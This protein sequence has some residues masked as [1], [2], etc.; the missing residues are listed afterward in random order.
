MSSELAAELAGR[1]KEIN[2]GAQATLLMI[3]HLQFYHSLLANDNSR[4][5]RNFLSDR[6]LL[7][8][9]ALSYKRMGVVCWDS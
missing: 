8:Y 7:S 4:N 9:K 6:V 2:A 1:Q 5:S 3:S